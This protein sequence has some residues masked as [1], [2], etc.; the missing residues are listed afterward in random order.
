MAPDALMDEFQELSR[1]TSNKVPGT[2]GLRQHSMFRDMHT[3][4]LHSSGGPIDPASIGYL[5][6]TPFDTPLEEMRQR[7]YRDGFLWV[8][9]AL[10]KEDVWKMR[11]T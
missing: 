10:P 4:Q 9:G 11:E 7:Y 6:P 3:L 1:P 8:K 2:D 5:K